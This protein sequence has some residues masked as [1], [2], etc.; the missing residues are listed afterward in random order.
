MSDKLRY[1]SLDIHPCPFIEFDGIFK[2]NCSLNK[3]REDAYSADNRFITGL[4]ADE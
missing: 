4:V 1:A 3:D 2:Q